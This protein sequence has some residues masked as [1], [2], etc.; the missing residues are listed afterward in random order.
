MRFERYRTRGFGCRVSS[1]SRRQTD[2]SRR[3]QNFGD[4]NEVVG[5]RGQYEEP[6]HEASAPMACLAQP[7]DGLD[8]AEWL[9]DPLSLDVLMR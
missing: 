8:P 3:S 2:S 7:A 5:G 9:F 4:A 1:F 6:L